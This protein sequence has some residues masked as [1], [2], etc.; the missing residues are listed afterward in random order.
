MSQDEF[1]KQV[2]A[3]L[4]RL[5]KVVEEYNDRDRHYSS[6]TPDLSSDPDDS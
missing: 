6:L 4:E 3:L 2:L 1:Q 5:V